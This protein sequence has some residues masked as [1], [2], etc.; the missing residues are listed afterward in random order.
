MADKRIYSDAKIDVVKQGEYL[1]LK[2]KMPHLIRIK[3]GDRQTVDDEVIQMLKMHTEEGN[4]YFTQ[5]SVS[6]D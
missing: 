4:K 1:E 6:I 2:Y 3:V 5:Q